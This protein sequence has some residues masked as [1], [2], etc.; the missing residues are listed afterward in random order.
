MSNRLALAGVFLA[1]AMVIATN[2]AAHEGSGAGKA[3]EHACPESAAA[4]SGAL[5]ASPGKASAREIGCAVAAWQLSAND[6]LYYLDFKVPESSYGRGWIKATFYIGLERYAAKVGDKRLMAHVRQFALENGFELGERTWH[7]DDQAVAA[8]YAALALR[9]ENP[10][11]MKKTTQVFDEIIARNYTNSL[12]FKEPA[13]G[14]TEGACQRRWCWADA[15]FMAPPSW[16]LASKVSGDPRYADYAAK[17][18]RAVVE[19]LQDPET[20]LLFRDSRY[21]DARTSN[22][23]KVFWS[24]GN[25]WVFAGLARFIEALPEDHPERPL[26]MKTFRTM[27]DRLI[28]LQRPDGYWPTSLMDA[29]LVTN[30]E[31]SGTGFFGFGLAW[32]LNNGV[33]EGEKYVTARDRSWDAMRAAVGNDGKLGWVQQ[34]GKD[35]QKT[36]SASSQLYG[37]GG[38]LL[39]AAEM[40]ETKAE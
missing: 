29:E 33:L 4:S 18:T 2:A 35:P 10:T 15:I 21:F 39:F 14:H 26:L 28:T 36:D 3:L 32:G 31:T 11:V 5:L 24:R 22:G 34:V 13:D 19:Y 7:G 30:P 6:N 23:K 9:D 17:E 20:G 25:G 27:A 12:E 1:S 16:A 8:V 37:V 38:M 40:L